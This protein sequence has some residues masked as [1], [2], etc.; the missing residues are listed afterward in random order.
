MV[1][2]GVWLLHA[3]NTGKARGMMPEM[4]LGQPRTLGGR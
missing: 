1:L 4:N 2:V 3:V